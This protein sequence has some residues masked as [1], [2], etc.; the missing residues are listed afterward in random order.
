[1]TKQEKL[2][3]EL[4]ELAIGDT[5]TKWHCMIEYI[6]YHSLETKKYIVSIDNAEGEEPIENHF[7]TEI[8]VVEYVFGKEIENEND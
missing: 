3:K 5:I 7:K 2:I 4:K 1:M 6:I 8:E